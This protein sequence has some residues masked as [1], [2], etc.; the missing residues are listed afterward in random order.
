YLAGAVE[1]FDGLSVILP[2]IIAVASGFFGVHPS[3]LFHMFMSLDAGV[4]FRVDHVC[5]Q[6]APLVPQNICL[7][8]AGRLLSS[9]LNRL[10]INFCYIE[11]KLMQ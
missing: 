11:L 2:N 3:V 4:H 5:Q 9:M 10:E 1:I 6:M 7:L 8:S